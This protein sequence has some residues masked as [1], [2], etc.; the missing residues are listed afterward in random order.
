MN[1]FFYITAVLFLAAVIGVVYAESVESDLA[2]GL[3]RLHVIAN[4]DSD[5]DQQIKL[6]VR[7][8]ILTNVR[9]NIK[10]VGGRTDVLKS[11]DIL[12]KAAKNKLA[13]LGVDYKARVNVENCYFPRKS[14]DGITLPAG[15][16][17]S[18]RVVLGEGEG[19]NWW[20][21]AYPPLCFTESTFGELSPEGKE[22]L[23]KQ[24]SPESYALVSSSETKVE[25]KLKIVEWVQTIKEKIR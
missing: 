5:Y 16:Y 1:K 20:C 19:Q 3:V 24:L 22:I 9:Q 4:S 12:E 17:E 21:V 23:Q 25:Y 7:D 18:I 6:A 13:A 10:R 15:R 11:T 8:E 14:Y 2:G